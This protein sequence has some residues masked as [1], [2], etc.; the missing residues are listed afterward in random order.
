[1]GPTVAPSPAVAPDA[2][3]L[4][5]GAEAVG[6]LDRPLPGDPCR[7]P[8]LT[9]LGKPC[10]FAAVEKQ[11]LTPEQKLARFFKDFEKRYGATPHSAPSAPD[12]WK[13]VYPERAPS[14]NFLPLIR[15]LL[16]ALKQPGP[17]RYFL[18]VARQGPK[19]WPVLREGRLPPEI[20]YRPGL[21]YVEL[22]AFPDR[23][24][25]QAAYERLED[26]LATEAGFKR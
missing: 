10:F 11:A 12:L 26:A 23:K 22:G 21:T 2:F 13:Q 16:D 1:M 6:R 24:G 9:K 5:R 25:A 19:A 20:A 7:E 18:Y 4:R 17:P 3:P 14:L 15:L 8:R